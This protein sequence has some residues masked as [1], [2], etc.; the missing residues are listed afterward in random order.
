MSPGVYRIRVSYGGLDTVAADESG[1]D[2]YRVQLWLA[3]LIA[4]R[5]LKQRL[6]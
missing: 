5:I 4:V 3:P 1:N 6:Q 2:H